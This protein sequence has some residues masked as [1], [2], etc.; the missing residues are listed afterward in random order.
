MG[1]TEVAK[2]IEN[3]VESTIQAK[4]VTFDFERLMDS[5]TLLSCSEFG[6]AVVANM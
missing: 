1:W 6:D 4:T 5:A 2:L 3:A